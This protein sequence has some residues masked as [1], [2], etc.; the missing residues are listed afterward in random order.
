[1]S[2]IIIYLNK[3]KDGSRF[4]CLYLHI[5]LYFL[6]FISIGT[7]IIKEDYDLFT[8]CFPV[9]QHCVF[10]IK[11]EFELEILSWLLKNQK[12]KLPH[13]EYNTLNTTWWYVCVWLC[14]YTCMNGNM[15]IVSI[16]ITTFFK[17]RVSIILWYFSS[18]L[19]SWNLVIFI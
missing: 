5:R 6:A 3:A 9:L 18:S 17:Q 1:M 13:N 2:P 10:K 8:V 12:R 16:K 4:I 15:H 11:L 14:I 7:R 19:I